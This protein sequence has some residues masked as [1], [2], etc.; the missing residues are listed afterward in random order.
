MRESSSQLAGLRKRIAR[1][2]TDGG[3]ASRPAEGRLASGHAQ[4]DAALGGTVPGAYTN[5]AHTC[6]AGTHL[7]EIINQI[8]DISKIEAGKLE[9]T[10]EDFELRSMLENCAALVVDRLR[11]HEIVPAE[12]RHAVEDQLGVGEIGVV[13]V[14]PRLGLIERRL[15]GARVDDGEKVAFLDVLAL[16][17]QHLLQLAIDTG[18]DGD[19]VERLDRAEIVQ[20]DR[21]VAPHRH[22]C[23][24]GYGR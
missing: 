22:G 24:H 1:L 13:L 2:A 12:L 21:H 16:L 6:T 3:P 9:I 18:A 4:F 10:A 11:A 14:S 15:E 23:F 7:L 19:R 8:L 5:N 17:E 20:M